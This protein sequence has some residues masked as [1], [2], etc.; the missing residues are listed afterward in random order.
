MHIAWQNANVPAKRPNE[1]EEPATKKAKREV[2]PKPALSSLLKK[3]QHTNDKVASS[4]DT[5]DTKNH[6]ASANQETK[7]LTTYTD[8][9]EATKVAPGKKDYIR[10]SSNHRPL[11]TRVSRLLQLLQKRKIERS[12]GRIIWL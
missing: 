4:T 2:P 9:A 8:V 1:G 11:L 12:D 10:P 7:T 6:E 5:N 3:V